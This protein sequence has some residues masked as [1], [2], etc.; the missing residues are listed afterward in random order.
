M[1]LIELGPFFNA[2]Q[3]RFIRGVIA[4]ICD[5]WRSNATRRAFKHRASVAFSLDIF[6]S[7]KIKLNPLIKEKRPKSLYFVTS[8]KLLSSF[9][10]GTVM[11][12]T[13]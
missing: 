1:A 13:F 11:I 10:V 4:Q 6:L 2:F 5:Y 8:S 12:R 3:E 9:S 7:K